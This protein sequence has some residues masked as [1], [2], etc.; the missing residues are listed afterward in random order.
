VAASSRA[1]ACLLACFQPSVMVKLDASCPAAS[2][3]DFNASAAEHWAEDFLG[4]HTSSDVMKI[5]SA[6]AVGAAGLL[7]LFFGERLVKPSFFVS[8]LVSGF[9]ASFLLVYGIVEHVPIPATGSCV[10]ACVV[11]L[12]VGLLAGCL[13]LKI[14]KLA[15][16]CL[17]LAGGG[18]LGNLCYIA[19]FSNFDTGTF[20]AGHDLIFWLS[21]IIFAVLG[22][23]LMCWLR[24]DLLIAITAFIGAFMVLPSLAILILS[25]INNKFLWVLDPSK[26]KSNFSSPFV[27]PQVIAAACYFAIGV[28]FQYRSHK[29]VKERRLKNRQM[30]QPLALVAP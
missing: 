3:V 30:E 19:I 16:L 5:I 25:R 2:L 21:I 8:S 20:I 26:G 6:A 22:A 9:F 15:F 7:L 18:A 1:A 4:E 27:Y 23:C 13:A 10:I 24:E 28:W 11:P 29:Q 14:L 17:G 12:V